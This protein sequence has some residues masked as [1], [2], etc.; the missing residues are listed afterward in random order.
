MEKYILGKDIDGSKANNIK[1]FKDLGKAAWRFISALY[2]SQWDNL[3][4]NRTNRSFRNNIKSKFSPQAVKKTA[5]PKESNIVYFPYIFSLLSSIPAK[6]AKK[7]NKI[8][9]YFKKQQLITNRKKSYAQISTKQ[10]NLTNVARETL[11]IKEAFPNLQNKKI[12]VIQKIISSQD[13]SKPKIN[14]TTKGLLH[15]QVIILMKDVSA[16]NFIKDSSMHVFN[17]NQILKNIKSSTIVDYIHINSKDI[18]IMTNNVAS[19][20]DLQAIEKYVKS[21][22]SINAD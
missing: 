15:K 21:I 11:K 3:I 10:S 22:S 12:E 8:S 2:T 19:L 4:V 20:S 5:K 7:V 1:D 16:N 17:I 9:K 18:V 13:K 14:I 6:S